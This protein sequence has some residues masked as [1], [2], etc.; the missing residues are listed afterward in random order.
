MPI[1]RPF[2]SSA[3][4]GVAERLSGRRR[5]REQ[6]YVGVLA[7]G[8]SNITIW[9]QIV[10]LG[11]E[12]CPCPSIGGTRRGRDMIGDTERRAA[13]S[14]RLGRVMG[15]IL[16]AATVTV[17]AAGCPGSGSGGGGGGYGSVEQEGGSQ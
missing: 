9:I 17:L 1:R 5:P 7:S 10:T 2:G 16:A 12:C 3:S 4:H 13:L 6:R 11:F 15:V 8:H 14:R